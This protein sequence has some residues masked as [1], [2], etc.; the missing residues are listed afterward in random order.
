MCNFKNY[1][2]IYNNEIIACIMYKYI[3]L[4]KLKDIKFKK[5]I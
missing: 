5:K 3:D 2:L 1:I 4:K